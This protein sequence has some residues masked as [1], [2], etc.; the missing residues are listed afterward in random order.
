MFW[1][2]LKC[3]H[4]VTGWRLTLYYFFLVKLTWYFWAQSNPWTT[5]ASQS[6]TRVSSFRGLQW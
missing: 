5:S 4:I 1:A 2:L 3:Q 6:S